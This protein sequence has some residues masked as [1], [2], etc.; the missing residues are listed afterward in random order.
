MRESE[1]EQALI[2]K[3]HDFLLELGKGFSFVARQKR[4]SDQT[5]H[6]SRW[7]S[8]CRSG[9]G[10]STPPVSGSCANTSSSVRRGAVGPSAT[11]SARIARTSAAIERPCVA[12]RTRRRAF[13][14]SSRFRII[15]V[16]PIAHLHATVA[17]KCS[18]ATRCGVSDRAGRHHLLGYPSRPAHPPRSVTRCRMCQ[19]AVVSRGRRRKARRTPATA[20]N[21]CPSQETPG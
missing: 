19:D 21:R 6:Y 5:D 10:R 14:S 4:I 7:G 18:T 13:T 3:L 1:L 16:E 9:R 15:S 2:D 12:A 17:C 11:A 8:T 20:P